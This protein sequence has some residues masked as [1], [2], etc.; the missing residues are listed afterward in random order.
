MRRYGSNG[1]FLE[2]AFQV[3]PIG[4]I[5]SQPRVAWSPS[6][7]EFAVTW[8]ETNVLTNAVMLQRVDQGGTLVGARS[9]VDINGGATAADVAWMGDGWVVVFID[10]P[11]QGTPVAWAQKLTP[12]GFPI[13]L[14]LNLDASGGAPEFVRAESG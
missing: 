1:N 6:T 14:P 5:V 9:R 2:N 13:G 7:R 4:A 3:S 8:I 11:F 10:A 12:E